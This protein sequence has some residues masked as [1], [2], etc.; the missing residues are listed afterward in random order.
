MEK[1]HTQTNAG[2]HLL[3]DLKSVVKEAE[4]WLSSSTLTGADLKAAKAKFERAITCA[5]E[6]VL[7]YQDLVV[8]TTKKSVKATD[9]YVHENPWRSIAI[10][11]SI[12][13]LLGAVV[14]RR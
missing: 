11:A 10:S 2:D 8:D 1:I 7:R 9:D 4:S 3:E 14:S 5:K 13:L 6:E 12:G